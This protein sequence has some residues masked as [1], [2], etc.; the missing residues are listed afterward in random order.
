MLC[1]SIYL[2][3][4]NIDSIFPTAALNT[5]KSFLYIQNQTEEKEKKEVQPC[6]RH[7]VFCLQSEECQ[8]EIELFHLF[9]GKRKK[10]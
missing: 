4:L 8:K 1:H 9:C 2:Y 10:R 3:P 6:K 5:K 7:A